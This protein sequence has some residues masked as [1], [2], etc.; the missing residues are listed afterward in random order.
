MSADRNHSK[1]ENGAKKT[2]DNN[3]GQN[4]V[5]VFFDWIGASI[6]NP[7]NLPS[8][9]L[10]IATAFLAAFACNAWL[11]ATKG[12]EALQ[13]A[14]VQA[15]KSYVAGNR[16]WLGPVDAVLD[17]PIQKDK[18]IKVLIVFENTGKGPALDVYNVAGGGI[19]MPFSREE[20]AQQQRTGPFG[21]SAVDACANI[22]PHDGYPA[23]FPD[24][25]RPLQA[26]V[27]Q[28][29]NADDAVLN[30]QRTFFVHGCAAYRTM[31]EVHTSEYCFWLGPRI[32]KVTGLRKFQPC[33]GSFKAN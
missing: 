26:N 31:G 1:S 22:T 33:L 20:A 14:N 10:F 2:P 24:T 15:N 19:T 9:L 3:E 30:G 21:G 25:N 23:I 27:Q 6:K 32:D 11:E 12:T 4:C 16:A 8:Y 17:G 7:H 13:A 29:F 18:P 28:V 5:C